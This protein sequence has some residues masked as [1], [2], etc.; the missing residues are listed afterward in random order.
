MAASNL[1]ST[2]F[3]LYALL[4]G[5]NGRLFAAGGGGQ[6][7]TGVPNVLE[8][9]N[10][11]ESGKK[12]KCI[13]VDRID[14]GQ[15][16]VMNAAVDDNQTY[17][18]I[19]MDSTCRLTAIRAAKLS[20]KKST[21]SPARR[22]RRTEESRSH[23]D[24]LTLETVVERQTDFSDQG[25][26]QKCVRFSRSGNALATG[27]VDSC[28]RIWTCPDMKLSHTLQGHLD[29]IDDLDFSSTSNHL[30]SVSRDQSARA[31]NLSSGKQEHVLA[32]D[33]AVGTKPYRFRACRYGRG[34]SKQH[35]Y[36]ALIPVRPNGKDSSCIAMWNG[37]TFDFVRS[38]KVG[39]D[40]ITKLEASSGGA[41]VAIG[42]SEGSI[43]VYNAENLQSNSSCP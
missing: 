11:E 2:D 31:W 3:P 21:G 38:S 24:G 7:R 23:A 14:V 12:L 6:A 39:H 27:G 34:K 29:E 26:F 32:K 40:P 22:R 15:H 33:K 18:A 43:S 19:G 10:V 41:Y 5:P 28:I 36:T 13:R 35:F 9:Y 8:I 37:K 16:A 20:S 25:A 4:A 17:V 1:F 42:T 30:V